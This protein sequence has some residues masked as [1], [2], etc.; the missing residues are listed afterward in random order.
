MTEFNSFN[1]NQEDILGLEKMNYSKFYL[2]HMTRRAAQ[3]PSKIEDWSKLALPNDSI[4]H[5]LSGLDTLTTPTEGLPDPLVPVVLNEKF[6]VYLK[7]WTEV[8]SDSSV[9]FGV[10]E[11]Y[12]YR[13]NTLLPSIMSFFQAHRKYHRIISD[14]TIGTMGGVL[15]WVDYSPLNEVR[16]NGTLNNYRKFDVIFRTILDNVI[17]IGE[18]KHHFIVLPQSNRVFNKAVLLR[19]FKEFST[20]TLNPLLDD[21]SIFPIIHLLGYVYGQ[22]RDIDVVPYKEDVKILGKDSEVFSKVKSTSLLER[23]DPRYFESINFVIQKDNGAIVYNLADLAKFSEDGN[24]YTK[25]Y[26]HVMNL[27]LSGMT[28]PDHINTDSD[29]FDTLVSNISGNTETVEEAPITST[30]P[31]KEIQEIG[32]RTKSTEIDPITKTDDV[33][34]I[35]DETTGVRSNFEEKIRREAVI[36]KPNSVPL[37]D[38][39]VNKKANLIDNHFKVMIG[40]KTLG[41]LI[42]PLPTDQIKPK[43]M[44]FVKSAP[45]ESYKK[46]SLLAMDKAYIKHASKHELAK[47]IG[48]LA[49]HGFY[50]T[51]LEE[52]KTNTEMDRMT[53]YKVNLSDVN[54]KVHHVKFTLPDVDDNGNMKLGGIEYRLTRQIAN[55][56]ICKISPTRVNLSSYYN[57]VIVERVQSKR[58]SYENDI[59]KLII[60]LKNNGFLKAVSGSAIAPTKSVPYDYTAIGKNFNQIYFDGY[61]FSFSGDGALLSEFNFD[62]QD[63]ITKHGDKFGIAVGTYKE[64]NILFWDKAN[65]IHEVDYR[66][67]EGK[68]VQS[69][70][71]FNHMLIDRLGS[72]AIPDKTTSE[73]VQ[74]NIINQTIPI[75]FILAFKMGLKSVLDKINL[76]YRFYPTGTKPQLDIMDIAIRF[77]DGHIVFN[78][79]PVMRSLIVAG[80]SWVDLKDI[81]F[82]DM[83]LP[84]TYAKIFQ[85]KGLS[86][87]VLK[88]LTGFFD[89]FVDPITESVLEKMGE[90]TTF[91]GLLFRANIMLSDYHSNESSSVSLHR[92]RLYERFNGMVYN[93]IFR[94]L[95]NHRNNPTTKK[96]FSINPEAVFQ[97]IVQD[98]TVS[99]N[100]VTN[101]VHEVKQRANFSFTGSG[102]RDAKSFV[103]KDRI[104][105]KDGLGVISDSVPDSGK[106]G[107]T[108]YLSSSPNIDDIHGI[109]KPYTPGDKLEP[110]QILSIGS[111]TLPGGTAD[112]GKRNS[113]LSIQISHYVPNHE[114]GETLAVRTGYDEVLPHL[115]SEVFSVAAQEDGVVESI[116]EKQKVLKVRYSDKTADFIKTIKLQYL[117]NII[118]QYRT[119]GKTLS[120]LI[121]ESEI[122]N[123]PMGGIFNFTKT[124][125][126]VVIDRL[127]CETVEAI[128]DKDISRKHSI[129]VNDLVR[130]KYKA[131][132]YIRFNTT[133]TK[134]PG[135]VRSYSFADMY[136][137]ISGSHLL[138]KRKV[139]VKEGDKF[140]EGDILLYNTGFFVE[141]PLSKQVTFK[142]GV[143]ATI[144][145][146]DKSSNH[147]DACEISR[148]MANRLKMT[149]AHERDVITKP[150]AAILKIVKVGDHVETSDSLCIISD[151]YLVHSSNSSMDNLDIMEKLNRQ[152]P[153]A[154]YTGHIRK[155]RL[156]YS[157][158]REELSESL[159]QI[160][161]VYEKE[162][163]ENFKSLNN[164]SSAK[165]PERP[166]WVPVGT[167][168]KGIS[169]AKDTVMIEF[170][171]E[172]TLGMAE[173]DKLVV[174]NSNKSIV[175]LVSEKQ[176]YTESGIPVDILFSTVSITNRIVSSPLTIGMAERNMQAL[177]EKIIGM[178]FD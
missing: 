73:W 165:P 127:R 104:Y 106:V 75:V 142:H 160:L 146:I 83:N 143:T 114:D 134:I 14:R 36:V 167:K 122:A 15:T 38:K 98:A 41:E 20:S 81:N 5:T 66:N 130:G 119:E 129:L 35:K 19:A 111:M 67:G 118:N 93:E 112:D 156:L 168:Y 89:F 135:E 23:I 33:I 128:P 1:E 34:V 164:D 47:V 108:A 46:S 9:P 28:I 150:D 72:E 2:S 62:S 153:P 32:T 109:P 8:A 80:L 172:E 113:Y 141:D 91:E 84:E 77:A 85:K 60:V 22:S 11:N 97:K 155:I 151:E 173:G 115:T 52:T 18:S 163:R 74:A 64:G 131:L 120:L 48:S 159:L 53:T 136:T 68:I 133:G 87:G 92:F 148:D 123:Y 70:L 65:Q 79:Y 58:N 29:K 125:N 69:W 144:A 161:K 177:K 166:G 121:P 137:P 105:P 24:F 51:K 152:T 27:R 6:P 44:S 178:Y 76:S 140:K 117:D 16:V 31:V 157:C 56:P 37:D 95:A 110:A 101:P 4:L 124:T 174:G 40:N 139:N 42:Q 54:G 7:V 13:P 55:V 149:P 50:A 21:P 43:D 169:F 57:K 49:K 90:P 176:H 99:P 3:A 162:S 107:I 25:M 147:E 59:A 10:K 138:Q 61:S 63:F 158:E 103:L 171:I 45:E 17:R 132:Y 100:D 88:G 86:V 71:S 30:K 96:A 170:M 82:R 26:R 94:E 126:G 12:I 116:D 102:G 39:T 154:D 78:R 145:L 175:S